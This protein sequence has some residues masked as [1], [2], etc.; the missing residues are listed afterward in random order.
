MTRDKRAPQEKAA[1]K[2]GEFSAKEAK[3]AGMTKA[4]MNRTRA[5]QEKELGNPLAPEK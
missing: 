5:E 4:E 1:W 3:E 2:A